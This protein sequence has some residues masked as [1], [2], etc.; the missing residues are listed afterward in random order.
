MRK[1]FPFA[2]LLL[3]LASSAFAAASAQDMRDA[4][5]RI[6]ERLPELE[7]L[8]NRGLTGESNEGYI[9]ARSSLNSTQIGWIQA[10]NRDRVILYSYVA[11]RTG[12]DLFEVS[13]ERAALIA[14][15]AKGGLW[16]QDDF[17]NWKRK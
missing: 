13:R 3:T 1:I 17:G 16:I 12:S 2:L 6:I 10:E 11:E 8:W 15:M 14:E 7:N 4:R 5:E 9:V